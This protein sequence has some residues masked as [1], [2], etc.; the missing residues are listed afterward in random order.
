MRSGRSYGQRQSDT[1]ESSFE[2][3]DSEA[4]QVNSPT[5][6][7][8]EPSAPG[9]RDR[10]RERERQESG[11]QTDS[12]ST[13]SSSS[14]P[15]TAD[16]ADVETISS[17]PLSPPAFGDRGN[18]LVKRHSPLKDKQQQ[19]QADS[20]SSSSSSCSQ[21]PD[22]DD[23]PTVSGCDLR[24]SPPSNAASSSS[25]STSTSTS[26]QTSRYAAAAAHPSAAFAETAIT[27]SSAA[28]RVCGGSGGAAHRRTHSAASY[29]S[30]RSQGGNSEA[31]PERPKR[32]RF[33]EWI[34][35]VCNICC[36]KS[37]G[38]GEPSVHHA[39]VVIFLEFFAWG[40]LT[41]PI[42]S[43]LNQTFPDHT[44]LMNGLVMGIKGILSFLSAPLIGALSDIWG[45]KFFLLVTVFFTCLPIPLMSI[46]TWWFFA[47]IS[48]SGAFAVTFSV[49]FAYVAD[50]TTPEERSKAYG[51]ASATFAASLVISPAL[52]NALM[53]MYGDTLVVA[54]STAIALL[55]VFFILV[56]VPESLSEKMRP[57]S[58]GAPISWEQADPF[59]A[60][61]K[62]GTDKTV[63]MLCLTV[64]LSYLPEAGEYSCM[65]VYLKL[66][67]GFNYVEVSV[68]IAIVGILSITVQVTL[69]SFM[70]VFGAKRTIIM[71][72]A[73]EIVQLLWYGFGS[74]KWMMWSAGVVAALG[75]ITYPA[76]SA[77]VS[78]YAAPE[79]QGAVQGMITGMRGLCNGLGP[80]VFGVVFYLFNVD[81]ND[82][83]DS[84]AKSSG[85]RATNVE[86]ISQHV[87]G[88]PFVFGAL[89][90]FCAIIVSAFIPEGQTSNLE[91]KR[92]SLDVQYEIETGHKAPSSLAPLIRSDSLA[93]L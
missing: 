62:V 30:M 31:T 36:C 47:M 32:N 63:L 82:D 69:G 85:S 4:E 50:V 37:S 12:L 56:A 17:L 83:H 27:A 61:R 54:L 70:Q 55:D 7:K 91:K 35:V 48:I 76:I 93:Q 79:S 20:S 88:P 6:A 66:K 41:M 73:L 3:E 8:G 60:L 74:Q 34:R 24:Q 14:T 68:F 46:N 11:E 81:L 25:S 51:L 28:G 84:H 72:L 42:I 21:Q 49:V 89:C 26:P 58:W 75:S 40:L 77:F 29:I 13:R 59:L 38:I 71:G 16:V 18:Q 90:V 44:F 19:Q 43:T 5:A 15:T 53:E 33:F 52:G 45:R 65:F 86:K 92:A 1:L 78:L 57:A 64:L 2:L 39:L 23:V 9:D 87:P 67:M 80:A 10:E 22:A